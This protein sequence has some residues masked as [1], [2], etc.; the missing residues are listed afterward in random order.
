MKTKT[1]TEILLILLDNCSIVINLSNRVESI[2]IDKTL[3][4]L[5]LSKEDW[6]Y[7]TSVLT[8]MIRYEYQDGR[9]KELKSRLQKQ[10]EI[11][12]I[13]KTL[14]ISIKR[15][16]ELLED[17]EPKQKVYVCE[18]DIKKAKLRNY[19]MNKLYDNDNNLIYYELSEYRF[20][21]KLIIDNKISTGFYELYKIN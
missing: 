7:Y 9:I 10:V 11:E 18:S 17:V 20:W 2:R 14:G 15:L 8:N 4:E 3:L 5:D 16:K 19:Q 13:E 1:Q 6:D 21:I 12:K